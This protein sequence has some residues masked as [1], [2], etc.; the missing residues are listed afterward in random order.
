MCQCLPE[1]PKDSEV[2]ILSV[3]FNCPEDHVTSDDN[4]QTF[5]F[6]CFNNE[7]DVDNLISV[8]WFPKQRLDS[9]HWNPQNGPLRCYFWKR[10]RECV[11]LVFSFRYISEPYE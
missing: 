4:I 9:I 6:A 1:A 5:D 8:G 2:Q 10:S 11:V 3:K 7:W